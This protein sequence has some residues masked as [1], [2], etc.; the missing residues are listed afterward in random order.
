MIIQYK[1]AGHMFN[2]YAWVILMVMTLTFNSEV[3]AAP[4]DKPIELKINDTIAELKA[5]SETDKVIALSNQT[6]IDS[7]AMAKKQDA[8]IHNE[9]VK[10]QM[11]SDESD[12]MKQTII[13]SGCPTSGGEVPAEIADRCNPLIREYN[14]MVEK[15]KREFAELLKQQETINQI[16]KSISDTTLA[17]AEK[18]KKNDAER[19]ELESNLRQLYAQ[20]INQTIA[21]MGIKQKAEA[22]KQCKSISDLEAA[23]CCMSVVMDGAD[24][25]RCN[26]VLV[27]KVLEQGSFFK[28]SVVVP[29]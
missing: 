20:R 15:I 3:L 13:D 1:N 2:M 9:L 22:A 26:V 25:N 4:N 27:Y 23:S 19:K 11:R 29:R 18:K 16:W 6:Q 28:T 5:N 7:T 21:K 17:N 8:R 24:P 12:R 10:L 14:S